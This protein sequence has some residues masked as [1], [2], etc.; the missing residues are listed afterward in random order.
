MYLCDM[1]GCLY[2]LDPN[3]CYIGV[4]SDSAYSPYLRG[5]QVFLIIRTSLTVNEGEKITLF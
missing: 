4:N 2:A 5:V 3:Y 1:G